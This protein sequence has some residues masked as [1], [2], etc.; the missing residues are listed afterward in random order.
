M[1]FAIYLLT[2]FLVLDLSDFYMFDCALGSMLQLSLLGRI[3]KNQ[4]NL[5]T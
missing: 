3:L 2:E 4:T 1:T 5:T